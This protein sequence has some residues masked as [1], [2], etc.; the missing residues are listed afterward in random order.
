[1]KMKQRFFLGLGS[2]LMLLVLF[3]F[4]FTE[5]L[6]AWT[7]LTNAKDAFEITQGIVNI[8]TEER[9]I[10]EVPRNELRA[11]WEKQVED[12]RTEGKKLASLASEVSNADR[13]VQ[14]AQ[15]VVSNC[16]SEI[17]KAERGI[18]YYQKQLE[19]TISGSESES[20][21]ESLRY[22]RQQKSYWESQLSAAETTLENE[23][24]TRGMWKVDYANQSQRVYTLSVVVG[25]A[26]TRYQ[27]AEKSLADKVR[28]LGEKQAQLAQDLAAVQSAVSGVQSALTNF[29]N[30]LTANEELDANQQQQIDDLRRD[31]DKVLEHLGL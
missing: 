26:W 17:E 25:N 1:M 22:W 11:D 27:N 31:L 3:A 28:E 15:D 4:A 5:V 24:Y 30:R 12:L 20:L 29:S 19:K 23:K 8:L 13:R 2:A 14:D 16:H 7:I 9:G 10:L 18:S 6:A 21:R